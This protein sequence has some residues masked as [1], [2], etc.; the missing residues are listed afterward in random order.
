ARATVMYYRDGQQMN[1]AVKRELAQALTQDPSEVTALMLLA[2]DHF[3][4]GRYREAAALWQQLLDEGRPR[5]N[6]EAVTQAL[7]TAHA[8]GG[9]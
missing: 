1:A 4:N 6:R 5:L 8:L 3:L 2:S 9:R 7:Q